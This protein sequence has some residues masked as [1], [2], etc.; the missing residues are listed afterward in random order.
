[1]LD[2]NI[3]TALLKSEPGIADKIDQA[4]TVYMSSTILGELYYGA[5]NSNQSVKLTNAIRKVL[6]ICKLFYIDHHTSLL[7]GEIKAQLRR[8]GK[9]IPENDIWIAASAKQHSVILISRDEH[10]DFIEGIT[11]SKW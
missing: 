4:D 2:T 7:Y 11:T 6:R 9:M 8:D 1:M 5:L 10:F 3:I